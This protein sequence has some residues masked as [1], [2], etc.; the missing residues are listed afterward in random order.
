MGG[1]IYGVAGAEFVSNTVTG[2]ANGAREG[3]GSAMPSSGR[4]VV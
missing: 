3:E 2:G 4:C 1:A